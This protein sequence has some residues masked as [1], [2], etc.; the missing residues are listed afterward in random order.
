MS[1]A[2]GIDIGSVAVKV[3]LVETGGRLCGMWSRPIL[4]HPA[5]T[6]AEVLAEVL[7]PVGSEGVLIGITG[8]GRD[9][10]HGVVQKESE[11]V[12]LAGSITGL[13]GLITAK[14]VNRGNGHCGNG[15][16]PVSCRR[17]HQGNGLDGSFVDGHFRRGL[18]G[19]LALDRFMIADCFR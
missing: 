17:R 18:S 16:F 3:A 5:Q 7:A 6:L 9:L 4:S 10:V 19:I 13:H 15:S 2:L 12:A 8:V 14:V 1:L 11:V